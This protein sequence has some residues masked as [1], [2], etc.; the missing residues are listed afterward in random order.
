M[1]HF[2]QNIQG[3]FDFKNIYDNMLEQAQ[4][5]SHFVEVGCWLG[6]SSSYMGVEIKNSSKDIRFDC[7]DIWEHSKDDPYY[8]THFPNIKNIYEVWEENMKK[9]G[10]FEI[11]HPTQTDSLTAAKS[12]ADNSLDFVFIDANHNYEFVK[13]DIEAW[14]PK[15]K[16]EGYI[17]GHDYRTGV[18]LA[19]DEFFKDNK[20]LSRTSWLHHKL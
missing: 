7:I 20:V 16:K 13:K 12:Y 8:I 19:V 5:G 14:Y 1:E 10:V 17:G 2:Y 15:V 11:I 18:K 9:S 6:K 3:W 4:N